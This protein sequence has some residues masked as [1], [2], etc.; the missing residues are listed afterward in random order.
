M[1]RR[2][3][4]HQLYRTIVGQHHYRTVYRS[5]LENPDKIAVIDSNGRYSYSQLLSA[6]VQL[7]EKLLSFTKTDEQSAKKRIAFLCNPD[8]SFVTAQWTCWLSKAI[9]IPLCKDHPLALLDYYVD[10]AKCSHL[11]VSPE[12][13]P[14]LKP[15]AD[16]YRIP[17]IILTHEDINKGKKKEYLKMHHNANFDIFSAGSDDALILYTS[18]TTGKPKVERSNLKYTI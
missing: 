3:I 15:L 18:G 1:L 10:D 8:A 7:H 9:C 17:L 2:S 11:I 4:I 14:L 13:E 6:S 5:A 12:Y 16:K